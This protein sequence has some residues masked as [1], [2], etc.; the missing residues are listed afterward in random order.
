MTTAKICPILEDMDRLCSSQRVRQFRRRLLDWFAVAQR[1]LPWRRHYTPYEIWISEMMLQQTQME[2]GVAYFLRWLEALPDVAAVAAAPEE[3]VLRLW[4]GLGYY[5]RARNLHKAARK[6]MEEHGGRFPAALEDIRRLPGVGPYTAAAI[7]GIA[8][9]QDVACVDAN[10]ER[11]LARV[12]DIDTPVKEEPAAGRIRELAQRLLPPGRARDYN[13]AM[14]ELGALLC[15][16]KP[17][18]EEGCPLVAL[19]ESHRL[20]ITGER[21]VPGKKVEIVSLEIVCGVLQYKGRF[22]LQ[23]RLPQG[24]WG[25]LWE[26][27]GGRI[28]AGERPEAAAVREFCEET[29]FCLRVVRPLGIIRHGYT[30]YRVRL[31]CFALEATAPLPEPQLTAATEYRWLTLSELGSVALPAAHRKL[32]DRLV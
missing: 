10:V 31:H 26:F 1:P 11:V 22:F 9:Q 32:A 28:E 27:P 29:G 17:R 15:R 25:G 19:C 16:K 14:M 6:I 7:A 13:Q 12:F 23:K 18:C 21:P 20:G 5:S 4:E 30:T 3:T 24:P 8:F 2:R